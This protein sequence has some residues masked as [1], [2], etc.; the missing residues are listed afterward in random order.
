MHLKRNVIE[1]SIFQLVA[2]EFDF[3][4]PNRYWKQKHYKIKCQPSILMMRW[5]I[6]KKR[7][8]DWQKPAHRLTG[9]EWQWLWAKVREVLL[10][11]G[12]VFEN[13]WCWRKLCKFHF[14]VFL[15][16]TNLL[17][18]KPFGFSNQ[19]MQRTIWKITSA[20]LS[21]TPFSNTYLLDTTTSP[22]FFSL[23]PIVTIHVD[24]HF[25]QLFAHILSSFHHYKKRKLAFC[26]IIKIEVWKILIAIKTQYQ[27]WQIFYSFSF[28]S[29]LITIGSERFSI[30]FLWLSILFRKH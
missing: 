10:M 14:C 24:D 11:D 1:L 2:A 15:Y 8:Q 9:A 28:L 5:E 23:L 20:I 25:G 12:S 22:H 21:R 27:K 6:C 16:E 13:F 30:N 7:E 3:K 18:G 26:I 29:P 19:Q 4:L 17:R